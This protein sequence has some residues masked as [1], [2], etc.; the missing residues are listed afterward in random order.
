MR[1]GWLIRSSAAWRLQYDLIV[2]LAVC[3][4]LNCAL[5]ARAGIRRNVEADEL[6]T[7][8]DSEHAIYL[9][10]VVPGRMNLHPKAGCNDRHCPIG[11]YESY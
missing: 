11:F 3:T 1:P 9:A 8:L 7:I 4:T 2:T 6:R 10:Y 5:G